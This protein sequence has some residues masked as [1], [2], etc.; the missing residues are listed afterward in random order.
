V[1]A[2]FRLGQKEFPRSP[3]ELRPYWPDVA[4]LA[5]TCAYFLWLFFGGA[6]PFLRRLGGTL[7]FAPL[8]LVVGLAHWRNS[9]L[10]VDRR[11][12]LAWQCLAAS[13]WSLW[14]SGNVW[15]IILF[16]DPQRGSPIWIN[17]AGLGFYVL[18]ILGCLTFPATP[19]RRERNVRFI[20]EIG[21]LAAGAMVLAV[22]FGLE[23]L[24][25][26]RQNPSQIVD[27]IATV[28]NWITV[29]VMPIAYLRTSGTTRGVLA[30]MLA[31][32]VIG[33][34]GDVVWE[35]ISRTSTYASGHPV[36]G[37][38]FGA[39][40]L[41]W[42]AARYAWHRHRLDSSSAPRAPADDRFAAE[43]SYLSYFIVASGFLALVLE[44]LTGD[45][46]FV[47]VSVASAA[48]MTALLVGRQV[49]ELQENRRLLTAL[50]DQEARFRS[51]VQNSSD[52][53]VVLGE[54]GQIA[55]LSPS[56]RQVFE[57]AADWRPGYV[58]AN[59]VHEEDRASF[60]RLLSHPG[61][62][63]LECRFHDGSRGWRELE[64]VSSDLRA[65]A[66]V[67]G[68]VLNCRD[69]SERNELERQLR[70]AQKLEAVGL[71]AGGIAHDFNNLLGVIRGHAEL[72]K[73]ELPAGS[74][75][76]DDAEQIVRA[77][78]RAA[79]VTRKILAFSRKQPAKPAVV[80]VNH[81]LTE[82]LPMLRQLQADAEVR[83][84][85]QP[86]LRRVRIDPG[87]L[88][89][90]V[91]NLATNARDAMPGG[92]VLSISTSN[93]RVET[94]GPVGSRLLD[95]V[96]ITVTDQGVG[97]SDEIR[98][99]IFEPFFT[100]KPPGKG[101]GLGLPV[102]YGIVTDA[103]GRLTVESAPDKGT[104]VTVFLPGTLD[105]VAAPGAEITPRV[106]TNEPLTVLLVDDEAGVRTVIRRTLER[107]GFGV[108][109]AADGFVALDIA[110][111]PGT[112][113]DLLLTDLV[114]PGMHGRDL[115]ARF[116]AMRP[117]IPIVCITG[118]VG[119]G[120]DPS[121]IGEGVVAVLSKPVSADVL[122]RTL[123]MAVERG[124]GVLK[125]PVER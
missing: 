92:G 15:S 27:V 26:A 45:M 65:D 116:R 105:S 118:F 46:K 114:M 64:I 67:G 90:V 95:W 77:S 32:T 1:T 19:V 106:P 112:R 123:R 120:G 6:D 104:A 99:R 4:A 80:D 16:F 25:L 10:T 61:S 21:L 11:T 89:Q 20:F 102:V 82:L 38:W 96:A 86:G 39:W 57:A 76:S 73:D 84:E 94:G 74:Q 100:T 42:A 48:V 121:D 49:V 13:C 78:D 63:R 122:V 108:A 70:H 37:F 113:I 28:F 79:A 88:E 14:I 81:V 124:E 34:V 87:Q 103:G 66:A 17:W 22:H 44:V 33:L 29:V 115:A 72:I 52:I 12:R 60:G 30:M 5:V 69:V 8:G 59:A 3:V 91:V 93:R 23:Q 119:E 62:G 41:R 83:L 85:C 125:R 36:D 68:I 40:V 97:M 18:N 2:I 9:G 71:L 31:A 53:V 111:R 117:D 98:G 58:L 35:A 43:D 51:L 55:Y 101:S 54:H 109:E 110:S 47:G 75:V 7:W 24:L 56:V 50:R 107:S